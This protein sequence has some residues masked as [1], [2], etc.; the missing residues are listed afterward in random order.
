MIKLFLHSIEKTETKK[1]LIRLSTYKS[2]TIRNKIKK[3]VYERKRIREK[4]TITIS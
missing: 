3:V 2:H 1:A 4:E